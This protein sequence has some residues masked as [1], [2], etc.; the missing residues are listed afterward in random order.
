[1]NSSWWK[2]RTVF[3]TGHT[4]FKG[5][6]MLVL[7]NRLGAR[8]CGYSLP[9][10]TNPSL[11]ALAK[12]DELVDTQPSDLRDLPKLTDAL[13]RCGTEIV[14]HMA[15]QSLVRESYHDPVGTYSTNLMGTVN[16]LEAVRK[17]GEAVRAVVV[18]TTDKCYENSESDRGYDETKP[19]GGHDPY[20]SSKACAEL[21]TSSYRRSF[22]DGSTTAIAT[23]RAGNVI[24]GG[25]WAKDRLIPDLIT[26]FAEGKRAIVRNPESIRPWQFVLDPLVGYLDLAER[27]RDKGREYAE[28]WN[29]GPDDSDAKSVR[30]VADELAAHWSTDAAWE[31]TPGRHPHETACL[32]L[33]ASK[34]KQRL[35]WRPRTDLATAL[36][37]TGQWYKAWNEGQDMRAVSQKQI[38]AF[39]SSSI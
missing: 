35:G 34:A 10:P 22:F 5:A 23:S 30:F 8:V 26:A 32:K 1:M 11:F 15:A 2:G 38:D 25:D 19:L 28:A 21:A 20:S 14:I 16:L 13:R 36:K 31:Q 33:D 12:L 18:V 6:W 7:L 9:P 17:A 4:G 24:G 39:L 27:L 3:L 37:W 29:F